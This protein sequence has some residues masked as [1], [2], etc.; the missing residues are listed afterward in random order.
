MKNNNML[1]KIEEK[2]IKE[3]IVF[4]KRILSISKR[5]SNIIKKNSSIKNMKKNFLIKL[6]NQNIK[7]NET[8]NESIFPIEKLKQKQ[9]YYNKLSNISTTDRNNESKEKL[10]SDMN[11]KFKYHKKLNIESPKII[12]DLG[13]K[14]NEKYKGHISPRIPKI[15]FGNG[16]WTLYH[17]KIVPHSHMSDNV[18]KKYN[19]KY[20]KIIINNIFGINKEKENDINYTNINYNVK[21]NNKKKKS[22]NNVKTNEIPKSNN[23]K[24]RNNLNNYSKQ[25]THFAL[26]KFNNNNSGILRRTSPKNNKE[27]IN[28]TIQKYFISSN[29]D[30]EINKTNVTNN[31]RKKSRTTFDK[32]NIKNILKY[33]NGNLSKISLKHNINNNKTKKLNLENLILLQNNNKSNNIKENKNQKLVTEE[34]KIKNSKLIDYINKSKL[35]KR[36]DNLN[37]SYN[38]LNFNMNN[39]FDKQGK[40]RRNLSFNIFNNYNNFN[41]LLYNNDDSCTNNNISL[42]SNGS[43]LCNNNAIKEKRVLFNRKIGYKKNKFSGDY[44]ELAKICVNQEKIISDLV[45][46]VQNLNNQICDKDLCINELNNQLYSIKY[47]LLNTLQKTNGKS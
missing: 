21:Q 35:N 44:F 20:N 18:N 22:N 19:N 38:N 43:I 11:S 46:N 25:V 31:S 13:I 9:L 14:D 3:G 29:K 26:H 36:D 47:D 32:L 23:I 45:K 37:S 41:P 42:L 28:K 8:F 34:I 10:N 30:R 5:D 27:I 15:I 2:P 7:N 4:K 1:E 12:L 33:K 39:T 24:K 17:G 16:D 6:P 40:K